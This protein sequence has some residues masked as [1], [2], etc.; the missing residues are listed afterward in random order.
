MRQ[1]KYGTEIYESVMSSA[2]ELFTQIGFSGCE[3]KAVFD[4]AQVSP[5]KGAPYF[6][7]KE[8]LFNAVVNKLITGSALECAGIL[9]SDGG[10]AEE[11]LEAAL[12]HI[13]AAAEK[14]D[15]MSKGADINV[16]NIKRHILTGVD[17]CAELCQA[18]QKWIEDGVQ[19]GALKIKSPACAANFMAFGLLGLRYAPC[20][21]SAKAAAAREY[22][23]DMVH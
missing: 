3:L 2:M 6:E 23:L 16:A 19:E 12:T 9:K 7:T 13:A 8:E 14:T 1:F 20:S 5:E 15:M 18:F 11:R 17:A 21:E 22:I 10:S 4:A